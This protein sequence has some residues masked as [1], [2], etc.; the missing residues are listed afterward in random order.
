M[1]IAQQAISIK[2]S[3]VSGLVEEVA[4][5]SILYSAE[6]PTEE[7]SAFLAKKVAEYKLVNGYLLS[8]DGK[9]IQSGTDYPK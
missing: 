1:D 3:R 9:D 7:K 8:T 5:N 2:L 4:S 6:V